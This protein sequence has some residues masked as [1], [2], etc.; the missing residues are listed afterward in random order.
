[1]TACPACLTDPSSPYALSCHAVVVIVVARTFTVMVRGHTTVDGFRSWRDGWVEGQ[2][3][4]LH[5]LMGKK[6]DRSRVSLLDGQKGT[7]MERRV[8]FL[9]GWLGIT[10]DSR[11][12]LLYGWLGMGMDRRVSFLDG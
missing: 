10:M 11:V 7:R 4:Q 8:L 6:R 12:L 3:E 1:M 2:V 5:C 9:D